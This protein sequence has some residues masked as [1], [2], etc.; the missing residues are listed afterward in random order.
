[1]RVK[2]TDIRKIRNNHSKFSLCGGGV[3]VDYDFCIE[4]WA[5]RNKWREIRKK[6]PWREPKV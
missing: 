4:E 6:G 1:M 2:T 5:E 3:V